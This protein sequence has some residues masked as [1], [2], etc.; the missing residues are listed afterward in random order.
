MATASSVV[1]VTRAYRSEH[2]EY[3]E[4]W[5]FAVSGESG[6]AGLSD[7]IL[8]EPIDFESEIEERRDTHEPLP[9]IDTDLT[10]PHFGV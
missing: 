5:E 10:N 8:I 3:L 6:V 4:A 9:K 7:P 2:A 1:S